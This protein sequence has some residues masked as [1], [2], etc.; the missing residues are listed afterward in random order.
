MWPVLKRLENQQ[1][2]VDE[3]N[4][5]AKRLDS[6]DI[7]EAAQFSSIAEARNYTSMRDLINLTFCCQQVTV[8]TDFSDLNAIG[9]DHYMN[10]HGAVA[11]EELNALDGEG[12][13]RQ[14]IESGSGTITPYGVV[15][16]NGMELEQLYDGQH[17]PCYYY[18]PN[19]LVLAVTPKAE[20]A[21]SEHI[22]WLYHPMP[23]EEIDRLLLRTGITDYS[24]IRLHLEESILPAKINQ[25]LD[26]EQES[27]SELNALAEV[28]EG[29][30][31]TECKKLGAV[32]QMAKPKSAEQIQHLVEHLDEFSFAPNVHTPEE[33]GRY[34]IQESGLFE[35]D[36]NLEVFYDYE[37]YGQISLEG[38]D[39][40]FTASGYVAC[41]SV[42]NLE[43]LMSA[44]D[45]N[46]K[47]GG[48]TP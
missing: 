31:E 40:M 29:L 47:L 48:M 44:D 41:D 7:Y 35:Y 24:Q 13:A 36:E 23:Q 34:M 28:I 20:P 10:L 45:E 30:S 2:D 19:I 33:Y 5:L 15:Y 14:L 16:D 22:T 1:I 27:L 25:A 32:V 37:K 3:L 46:L 43:E 12:I 8:I 11:T 26:F 21:D 18:Q 42:Q 6:F 38:K 17:F 4:Y 9:R 39:G